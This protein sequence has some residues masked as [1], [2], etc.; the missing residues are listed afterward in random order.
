ME[1]VQSGEVSVSR[2]RSPYTPPTTSN[3]SAHFE[4]GLGP[5]S[6]RLLF[7]IL[8]KFTTRVHLLLA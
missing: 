4:F 5:R 3:V 6:S 1:E 2:F 7:G 8:F